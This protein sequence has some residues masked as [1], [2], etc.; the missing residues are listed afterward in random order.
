M[1]KEITNNKQCVSGSCDVC[2]SLCNLGVRDAKAIA[3][4]VHGTPA[5]PRIEFWREPICSWFFFLTKLQTSCIERVNN[6]LSFLMFP[7]ATALL[8]V[9]YYPHL[10]RCYNPEPWVSDEERIP[11]WF[12]AKNTPKFQTVLQ[13][14]KLHSFHHFISPTWQYCRISL[15][16]FPYNNF[17]LMLVLRIRSFSSKIKQCRHFSNKQIFIVCN[18]EIMFC[19]SLVASTLLS[20]LFTIRRK[21]PTSKMVLSFYESVFTDHY[22]R[23]YLFTIL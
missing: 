18:R 21:L 15:F 23:Q 11:R 20:H 12:S 1:H 2:V 13:Q 6:L 9:R 7:W 19:A 8:T 5:S 4:S 17:G 3:M 10:D 16:E 22:S 14:K